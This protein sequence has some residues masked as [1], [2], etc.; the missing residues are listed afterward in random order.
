[1]KGIG[2]HVTMEMNLDNV[3]LSEINQAQK[4][5]PTSQIH[6]DRK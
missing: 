6:T 4:E 1:M 2:T 3:T 5:V